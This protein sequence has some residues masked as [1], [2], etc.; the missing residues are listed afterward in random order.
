MA[1]IALI[2]KYPPL[3]GGISSKTYWL[4]NALAARGHTIHIITD[5]IGVDAVHTI[6]GIDQIPN[7]PN[8][9]VHRI[10]ESVPWHI[11]ND[12][13]R[14]ISLL[15]KLLEVLSRE[16]PDVIASNYLVPYGLAAF[17][18][19]Q[20]TGIPYALGHGGSD[21]RKFVS[22]GIWPDL[23]RTV[24]GQA[25]RVM[26]DKDSRK[27]TEKLSGHTSCLIPYI[28]DSTFFHPQN[29]AKRQRPVLGLI[30]KA[31]YHWRHKGWH[32]AID[33]WQQMKNSFDFVVISQGV[34]LTD[35]RT[36]VST[37]TDT[38]IIWQD[39]IP[40]WE[41]PGL[42]N[43]IDGLFCFEADLPFPMYSNVALEALFCG[44][45]IFVDNKC[46][47]QNYKEHGLGLDRYEQG[48]LELSDDDSSKAAGQIKSH[49]ASLPAICVQPD[50]V[51]HDEYV[52]NYE[53]AIIA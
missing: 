1:K 25:K 31:N 38:V 20:I 30:G 40:P 29:R 18:A 28:P 7:H 27:V 3:E 51:T 41:M 44:V 8:I 10:A 49:F 22:N 9:F 45:S 23:W 37:R 42:L 6:P 39:F 50:P 24:L 4:S 33:I 36:Y 12:Q 14:V 32:R 34:G 15:N 26:T 5:G 11:P 47:T 21:I 19:S 52:S 13:H 16:K 53:N 2:G 46:V 48:V 43:Q 35:F 17:M